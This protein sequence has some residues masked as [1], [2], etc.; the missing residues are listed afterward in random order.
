MTKT[1]NA[2]E[3]LNASLPD[4]LVANVAKKLGVPVSFLRWDTHRT[5]AQVPV[6]R[7]PVEAVASAVALG[8]TVEN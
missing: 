3:Q 1:R 4:R 6:F 5:G 2:V 7:V 8:L